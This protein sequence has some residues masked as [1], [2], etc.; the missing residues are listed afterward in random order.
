MVPSEFLDNH[1]PLLFV[2]R[3]AQDTTDVSGLQEEVIW[4]REA[5]VAT[6]AT[7]AEAV[8]DVVAFA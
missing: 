1:F 6:E 5:T 4:A 3:L 8:C 7:C 2:Q